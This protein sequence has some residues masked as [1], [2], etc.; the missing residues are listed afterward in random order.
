M[1]SLT[2]YF[3]CLCIVAGIVFRNL[4]IGV[5]QEVL[6]YAMICSRFLESSLMFSSMFALQRSYK[7][8]MK[9]LWKKLSL[10]KRRR[11]ILLVT[12]SKALKDKK[13]L[14]EII[15]REKDKKKG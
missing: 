11:F 3:A 1:C 13:C 8:R 7:K 15:F 9:S 5:I 2:L 14:V 4:S 6:I 12:R 10:V